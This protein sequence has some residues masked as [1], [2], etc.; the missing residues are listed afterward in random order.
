MENEIILNKINYAFCIFFGIVG[1]EFAS[2]DV[3]RHNSLLA[4]GVA[5]TGALGTGLVWGCDTGGGPGLYAGGAGSYGGGATAS[6]AADGSEI[7]IGTDA[8]IGRSIGVAFIKFCSFGR[9]FVVIG[10]CA[11]VSMLLALSCGRPSAALE[12]SKTWLRLTRLD[13]CGC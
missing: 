7:G 1:S 13:L 5:G 6:I 8:G 12:R 10:G 4:L 9:L 2:I 3:T 11:P